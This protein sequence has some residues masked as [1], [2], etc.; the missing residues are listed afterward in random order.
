MGGTLWE[1]SS[2]WLTEAPLDELTGS[3]PNSLARVSTLK[4]VIA[5][6]NQ[7]YGSLPNAFTNSRKIHLNVKENYI[8]KPLD[9]VQMTNVMIINGKSAQALHGV[10]L[11]D[12]TTLVVEDEQTSAFIT[13]VMRAIEVRGGLL[14]LNRK[15][16]PR[17]VDT[18]LVKEITE[19]M[20]ERLLEKGETIT[21]VSDLE[22]VLELYSGGGIAVPE[23]IS[24]EG[25]VR[26]PL[27][28]PNSLK[29]A[30]NGSIPNASISNDMIHYVNCAD[31][32]DVMHA[33]LSSDRVNIKGKVAG[34]CYRVSGTN[35]F[36]VYLYVVM[37]REKKVGFIR[38]F[39]HIARSRKHTRLNPNLTWS[40]RTAYVATS[41]R[42]DDKYRTEAEFYA[43]SPVVGWYWPGP[44][45]AWS[46]NGSPQNIRC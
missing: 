13:E 24:H 35:N 7:L 21:T 25:P 39:K 37:A 38:Y 19:G 33:H 34:N 43:W 1:N 44:W 5:N 6:N 46:I 42:K 2:G 9:R 8:E 11:L 36:E 10:D 17:S 41:C 18:E 32:T 16:L 29:R 27:S 4:R 12:E 28:T 22:R 23:Q 3:I 45:F 31:R 15:V 26:P 20:N 14:Y 40:F 30:V